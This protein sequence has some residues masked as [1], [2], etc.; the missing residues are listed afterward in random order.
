MVAQAVVLAAAVAAFVLLGRS[1]E[2]VVSVGRVVSVSAAVL[3]MGVD[4]GLVAM[5]VGAAAGRRG[6]ALAAGTALAAGSYVV[7]SLAPVAAWIRPARFASLFYWSVGNGQVAS[8]VSLG[9]YGALL[10]V[11]LSALLVTVAAFRRLDIP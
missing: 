4:F 5:A 9:D 7:S 6:A 1:F 10:L 8:G 2:L 11:G 3:L